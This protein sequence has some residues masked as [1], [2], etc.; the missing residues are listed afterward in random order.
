MK[1][2]VSNSNWWT[3]WVTYLFCQKRIYV[4]FYQEGIHYCTAHK[5]STET[6]IK[7]FPD[8]STDLNNATRHCSHS[9]SVGVDCQKQQTYCLRLR[10]LGFAT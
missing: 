4:S 7:M 6:V 9:I 10:F 5:H 2:L 1:Y 3:L 8:S